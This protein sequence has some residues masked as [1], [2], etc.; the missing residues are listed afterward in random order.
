MDTADGAKDYNIR[1][2]KKIA[3]LKIYQKQLMSSIQFFCT[4]LILM[5]I[6]YAFGEVKLRIMNLTMIKLLMKKKICVGQILL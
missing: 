6:R 3:F 5:I 4:Y 2:I 1:K